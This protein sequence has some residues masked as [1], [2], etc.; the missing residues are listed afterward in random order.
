MPKVLARPALSQSRGFS[1]IEILI[2]VSII[3]I[4]SSITMVSIGAIQRGTR[5]SAKKANLTT[6]QSAL[7]H[8]YADQHY[9]PSNTGIII[10]RSSITNCTGAPGSCSVSRT[11]LN[12]IPTDPSGS[13]YYYLAYPSNC[14]NSTILCL[15]YCLYTKLENSPASLQSTLRCQLPYPPGTGTYNYVVTQP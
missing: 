11:Y 1:L 3:G 5:D 14:N 12:S 15:D 6:I 13:G 7:A 2:A 10:G 8:Y 4:L 9:Y